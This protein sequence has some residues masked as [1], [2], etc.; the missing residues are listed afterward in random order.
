MVKRSKAN[1]RGV[2]LNFRDR[3]VREKSPV[4][5]RYLLKKLLGI[6]LGCLFLVLVTTIWALAAGNNVR[7]IVDGQDLAVVPPPIISENRIFLPV[8]VIAETIG[9]DVT[10]DAANRKVFINTPGGK[11]ERYLQGLSDQTP[12]TRYKAKPHQRSGFT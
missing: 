6:L 7:I 3:A 4:G 12:A 1:I 8:R 2:L 10:W 5:G 9:T 11:G